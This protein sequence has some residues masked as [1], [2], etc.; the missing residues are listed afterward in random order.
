MTSPHYPTRLY[1]AGGRGVARL[2]GA[3][4]RLAAPPH[5]PTLVLDAIDYVPGVLAIV[6]PRGSGWR[7]ITPEERAA[8]DAL[9]V[10]LTSAVEICTVS[11]A[12][13]RVVELA[14]PAAQPRPA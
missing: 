14:N 2:R 5:L 6:M 8:F 13:G 12:T 3:E 1:W 11:F 9:L 7:D 10:Q 4:V